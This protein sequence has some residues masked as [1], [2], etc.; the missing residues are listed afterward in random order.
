MSHVIAQPPTSAK[1]FVN[2][3][4]ITNGQGNVPL[5]EQDQYFPSLAFIHLIRITLIILK[6]TGKMQAKYVRMGP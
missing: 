5:S 3:I 6:F 1:Q 2:A 4:V